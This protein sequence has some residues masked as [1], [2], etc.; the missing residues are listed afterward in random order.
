MHPVIII[1]TSQLHFFCL[2]SKYACSRRKPLILP[3]IFLTHL[4]FISRPLSAFPE[5]AAGFA[6]EDVF[7]YSA[8]FRA[9]G[10]FAGAE[11]TVT[12]PHT[13]V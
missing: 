13:L 12:T 1:N 5:P 8:C 6:D 9:V 3:R 4:D 11:A 7:A 2:L 10:L